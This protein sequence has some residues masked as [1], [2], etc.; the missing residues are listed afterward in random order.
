MPA[1]R[2]TLHDAG[3]VTFQLSNGL[4]YWAPRSNLNNKKV[5]GDDGPQCGHHQ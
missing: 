4:L 5:N 2:K 3:G 1:S